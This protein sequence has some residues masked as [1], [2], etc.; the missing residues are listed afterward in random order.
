MIDLL[1]HCPVDC[2]KILKVVC[3]KSLLEHLGMDRCREDSNQELRGVIGSWG[4]KVGGW[5]DFSVD[6]SFWGGGVSWAVLTNWTDLNSERVGIA[7]NVIGA[8]L[9]P[10]E[11]S[12]KI[13]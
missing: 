8:S 6:P 11:I 3:F 4:L 12:Q 9:G 2:W 10:G 13:Y 7:L 5:P 1:G